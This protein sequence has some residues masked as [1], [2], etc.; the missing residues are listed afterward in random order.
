MPAENNYL[1]TPAVIRKRKKRAAPGY[2]EPDNWQPIGTVAKRVAAG[3]V[4]Q[5]LRRRAIKSA[6]INHHPEIAEEIVDVTL[7][8]LVD[9]DDEMLAAGAEELAL[10]LADAKPAYRRD[11][12]G[13]VWRAMM[14]R[15]RT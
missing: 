3:G 12:A 9:P 2:C 1:V 13:V 11:L 14:S 4:S 8:I 10:A 5:T 15:V 7:G 6:S